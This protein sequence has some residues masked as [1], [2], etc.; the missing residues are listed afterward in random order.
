MSEPQ[1]SYSDDEPRKSRTTAIAAAACVLLALPFLVLGPYLLNAKARVELRCQPGGVCLLFHSSWL[2]RDEVASFA[3]KDV[4]G[5]KV[6]RTRAAR[7]NRV[8]IFR[9][10]LVT[11]H[12]EYPLFFQW[13]TEEAEATRAQAE[14]EQALA[15]PGGQPVVFVRDDRN[16]SLRVGGAFSGVGLLLLVFAAWL[17]WRTR[18]H[19]RAE[20]SP[21][22]A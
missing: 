12:G 5:V 17:G 3:M 6:D 15:S 16:A 7:R 8:P 11:A 4:R 18:R 22:S 19:L 10:T 1:P 20:R 21:A 13:A 14:L 2:T 9:P